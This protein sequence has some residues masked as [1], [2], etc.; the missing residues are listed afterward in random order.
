MYKNLRT[1]ARDESAYVHTPIPEVDIMRNGN[2]SRQLLS[3]A[4]L[5]VL[6]LCFA[7][8]F[9]TALIVVDTDVITDNDTDTVANAAN[10][11]VDAGGCTPYDLDIS[12][13]SFEYSTAI[14]GWTYERSLSNIN[15]STD[16]TNGNVSISKP[17]STGVN[18][19]ATASGN[20]YVI[21]ADG[22]ATIYMSITSRA[23][24]DVG[25]FVKTMTQG[26]LLT[27]KVTLNADVVYNDGGSNRKSGAIAIANPEKAST[28][29][30]RD[31][32]SQTITLTKE[33]QYIAFETFIS[34]QAAGL[35][36]AIRQE[37]IF[38]SIKIE[39][40]H[41][42]KDGAAPI[43]S[44]KYDGVAMDGVNTYAPYITNT[45]DASNQGKFPVFY[46]SI[47]NRLKLDSVTNGTGTLASYTNK[48]LGN[49]PGLGG[50]G[51]Y[52][53]AQTEFVDLFN[54][55]E[56]DS[57]EAA[58][59]AYGS[60]APK[61]IGIGDRYPSISSTG[62]ITWGNIP[63][64]IS[65]TGVDPRVS[66]IATVKVGNTVFTIS[67]ASDLNTAKEITVTEMVDDVETPVSVG[68]AIVKL[69]NRARVVV[70][71]YFT[72]NC[73]VE[74]IVT[75]N[76]GQSVTT[77]LTVSGI[78]TTAPNDS[79]NSGTN[80][81]LDNFVGANGSSVSTLDWFRQNTITTDANFE[82]K[83]EP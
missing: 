57:I 54:Y 80:I 35:G 79:N 1:Y 73:S 47:K 11:V 23:I 69:T 42:T 10:Y 77:N 49:V 24:F 72:T 15:L 68:Y 81:F 51:Y 29:T 32:Y 5:V 26:D 71:I 4:R 34:Q 46:D 70:S 31:D 50:K 62:G 67:N 9:A 56:Y 78:D 27:V 18:V 19:T 44:S 20:K 36:T 25:K 64:S 53:F 66:G 7:L 48:A 14:N 39:I 40:V 41:G 17:E 8:V 28:S 60:N 61:F 74:T 37:I 45:I 3:L 58:A 63:T 38:N 43:V 30:A 65:T 12:A 59:A 55:T 82:I 83:E 6:A 21:V 22:K 76:G 75:D 52:K 33:K 13:S 2:K 16:D